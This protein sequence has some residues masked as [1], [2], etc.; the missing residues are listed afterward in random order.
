MVAGLA[1]EHRWFAPAESGGACTPG[2]PGEPAHRAT[3]DRGSALHPVPAT[4]H[5]G[6]ATVDGGTA[7][8]EEGT[9]AFCGASCPLLST[10]LQGQL[11]LVHREL[12]VQLCR[13][14]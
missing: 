2:A 8:F 12:R 4:L 6:A 7:I 9:Q 11:R 14:P 1:P 3:G 5:G 10:L 13:H